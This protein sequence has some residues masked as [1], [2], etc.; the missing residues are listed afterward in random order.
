MITRQPDLVRRRNGLYVNPDVEFPI[1][2]VS[3]KEAHEIPGGMI[4]RRRKNHWHY[5]RIGT[6]AGG[7]S[8]S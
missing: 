5:L 2:W 6:S 1:H 3:L 4:L 8:A 7:C